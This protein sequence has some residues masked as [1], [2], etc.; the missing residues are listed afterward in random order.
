MSEAYRVDVRSVDGG[1]TAL[2]WGGSTTVVIDRSAEAGGRGLGFNGGQ[3][4]NLGRSGR[5][6][7]LAARRDVA[8]V[9]ERGQSVAA[10]V[11]VAVDAPIA[12]INCRA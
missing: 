9:H 12:A 4:L 10:P 8:R 3:L 11:P 7:R 2:G 5:R 1:P 6:T